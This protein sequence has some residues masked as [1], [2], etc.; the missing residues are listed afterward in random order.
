MPIT[1]VT[2]EPAVTNSARAGRGVGSTKSPVAW[3]RWI[4]V[5]GCRARTTWLLT[6]P[7][8]IALTVIEISP[9][10]AAT[11]EVSE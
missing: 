6:L 3:S 7:S 11:G 10:G 8:G 1:G 2:P 9:S 5:P 4:S